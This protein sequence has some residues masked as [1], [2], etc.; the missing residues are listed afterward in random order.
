[1]S[2]FSGEPSPGDP[3]QNTIQILASSERIRQQYLTLI[4]TASSEI[5]LIFPTINAVHREHKIGIVAELQNAV[6]RG[7]KIRILSAED[8]FIKERLDALRASGMIVRSIETPTESK[9]K[10][11]LVDKKVAFIVETKDD[12][13]ASFHE[14]VGLAL[15]SNSKPTVLPYLTIFESFWRETELYERARESD[16]IKDEFVNIAAHEL[17]NPI[18]P[19]LSGADLLQ[20]AIDDIKGN[21]DADKVA[22]LVSN[23]QLIVRNASKLFKLSEDILQVSRIESGTFR[24]KVEFVVLEP[25][26][27]YTI[28]DVEKRYAGEKTDTRLVYESM[29]GTPNNSKGTRGFAVYCDSAKIGQTLFNLLDNA[30]KFTE[31]G[32]I[33]VSAISHRNEVVVQVRDPGAGIDPDIKGRLFEKFASKSSG[34]TGLGLY[35][36]RRII[37]AHGG[38]IW[39]RDSE[40]GKGT[41]CGFTIPLDLHPEG[42]ASVEKDLDEVNLR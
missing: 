36:S 32:D 13:K 34:G 6:Q 4:R 21:I 33:V 15:L 30:M 39:C 26:I 24:L 2:Q 41:D 20:A 9:F 12:S 28:A 29:L 23:T 10:M 17:R 7:V 18:M 19:I 42:I 40:I 11:L 3:I 27:R 31:K 37:E 35:L 14:A 1:M 22:D 5:L 16:R 38:R 8:E 25:L